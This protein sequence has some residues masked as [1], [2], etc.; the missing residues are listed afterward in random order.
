MPVPVSRTIS[1]RSIEPVMMVPYSDH[2]VRG[3]HG[4]R[5]IAGRRVNVVW[6]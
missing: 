3:D 1:V 6:T 4:D 5:L 2:Y